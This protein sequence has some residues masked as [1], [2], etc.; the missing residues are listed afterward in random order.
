MKDAIRDAIK[1][2]MN[3]AMDKWKDGMDGKT[4]YKTRLRTQSK[5]LLRTRLGIRDAFKS[6]SSYSFSVTVLY[7]IIA[8]PWGMPMKLVLYFDFFFF[9]ETTLK[10]GI[11]STM[12]KIM[13][14]NLYLCIE[15]SLFYLI[16]P[17][18]CA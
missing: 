16:R 12:L 8:I 14:W 13:L 5:A 4:I 10:F 11:K 3:E 2:G 7:F 17:F 9:L 15:N 6:I 18:I 1:D